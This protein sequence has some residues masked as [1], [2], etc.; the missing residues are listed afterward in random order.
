MKVRAGAE[1]RIA[2]RAR[3]IEEELLKSQ[4]WTRPL[5]LNPFF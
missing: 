2:H 1:R 5:F 3:E 4:E